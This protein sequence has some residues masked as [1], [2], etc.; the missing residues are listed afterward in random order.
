MGLT[1][2]LPIVGAVAQIQNMPGF[3]AAVKE[4]NSS[5]KSVGSGAQQIASGAVS[6]GEALSVL[7]SVGF[8]AVAATAAVA[9]AAVIAFGAASAAI[10]VHGVG[11][12]ATLE[13]TGIQLEALTG[14][15]EENLQ[16]A[17]ELSTTTPFT[18]QSVTQALQMATAYGFT[19]EEAKRI[20]DITSDVS[21]AFGDQGDRMHRIIIALGQMRGAAKVNAQDMKQLTEAGINAWQ[22]LADS[23][24]VSIA[25]VREQ[26]TDGTISTD[27]AI[28]ALT[29]AIEKKFGGAAERASDSLLG[30]IGNIHNLLDLASAEVAFPIFSVIEEVL[31]GIRT[32]LSG[33]EFQGLISDVRELME[34]LASGIDPTAI[35][36]FFRDLVQGAQEAVNFV[37]QL[38]NELMGLS[39]ADI[40]ADAQDRVAAS[41]ARYEQSLG[42][43]AAAHDN[44]IAGLNDQIAEAGSTL[45]RNLADIESRYAERASDIAERG[46]KQAQD[47]ADQ[48]LKLD[49]NLS[50]S[51]EDNASSLNDRL[52]SLADD[53]ADKMSSINRKITDENESYSKDTE[54]VQEGLQEDLTGVQEKYGKK[55]ADLEKRLAAAKTEATKAALRTQIADL[56]A[57]QAQEEQKLRDAATKKQ[58]DLDEE[59][60]KA[61]DDLNRQAAEEQAEYDKQVAKEKQR[62][63]ER[64]E[65][66]REDNAYEVEELKKKNAEQEAENGKQMAKLEADKQR[67]IS[68]AQNSNASQVQS[69]KDRIQQENDAYDAQRAELNDKRDQDNANIL[70]DAQEQADALGSGPAHEVANILQGIQDAAYKIVPTVVDT[71][72]NYDWSNLG[73][74]IMYG[75]GYG[76]TSLFVWLGTQMVGLYNSIANWVR[77]TDWN[78]LGVDILVGIGQGILDTR[79]WLQSLFN[80]MINGLLEGTRDALESHSP[81]QKFRRIAHSIPE[82]I[83]QALNDKMADVTGAMNVMLGGMQSAVPAYAGGIGAQAA[84]PMVNVHGGSTTYDQSIEVNANYQKTQ[85]PSTIRHDLQLSQMLRRG[86]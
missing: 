3:R 80:D 77:T 72:S 52:E 34:L 8:A 9:T 13:Q 10:V 14:L 55:R 47:F 68:A 63:E 81:S 49:R 67:E 61:L 39:G 53:H 27:Q 6:G 50:R 62:S 70:A 2:N 71:I 35:I 46:A 84:A 59:H 17:K 20:V 26:V 58:A 54:D 76:M 44:V 66:I 43:L 7:A 64:A 51:L 73:H 48:M 32:E 22:I 79:S 30:V 1:G 74:D 18:P 65:R 86:G 45:A 11:V 24:G 25:E 16:W 31:K 82:G 41:N 36:G 78:Q 40:M 38:R 33:I 28:T 42:R 21:A 12:N 15:G 19:G 75:I 29:D 23:V 83:I 37:R 5:L 4:V 69:L 85:D 57:Q 60:Q 56:D